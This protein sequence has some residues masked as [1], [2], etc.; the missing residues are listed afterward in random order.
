MRAR[1]QRGNV[2]K[3]KKESGAEEEICHLKRKFWE[4]NEEN[5]ELRQQLRNVKDGV[6][7]LRT[8]L[9]L[10]ARCNQ[11]SL[12][13]EAVGSEATHGNLAEPE[14]NFN[15]AAVQQATRSILEAV[16]VYMQER[17]WSAEKD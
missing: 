13:A 1:R 6:T 12:D 7:R 3:N 11:R 16:C 8:E 9:K 17:N 15:A 14:E 2:K 10:T 4:L 5:K